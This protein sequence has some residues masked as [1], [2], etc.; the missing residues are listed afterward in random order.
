MN[1]CNSD[2]AL[3]HSEVANRHV[4]EDRQATVVKDCAVSSEVRR[5]VDNLNESAPV[6]DNDVSEALGANDGTSL[7]GINESHVNDVSTGAVCMNKQQPVRRNGLNGSEVGQVRSAAVQ[8]TAQ[9]D[10]NCFVSM[11]AR[12]HRPTVV[13]VDDKSKQCVN[14]DLDVW[15]SQLIQL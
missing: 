4:N 14:S 15:R 5:A 12:K 9:S 2:V 11:N 13:P 1:D 8:Q 6:S 7:V 3:V 10:D